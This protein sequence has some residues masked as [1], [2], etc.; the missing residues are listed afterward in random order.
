[1]DNDMDYLD[2]CKVVEELDCPCCEGSGE[3]G[4]LPHNNP[5]E[6]AGT[7]AAC[8]GWGWFNVSVPKAGLGVRND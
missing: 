1:M 5:N 6:I 4:F 3:H 7:C 8:A 2:H